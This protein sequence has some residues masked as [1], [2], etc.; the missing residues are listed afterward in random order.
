M[1]YTIDDIIKQVNFMIIAVVVSC[2]INILL[3]AILPHFLNFKKAIKRDIASI[4]PITICALN[5]KASDTPKILSSPHKKIIPKKLIN[6][7]TPQFDVAS[8][9]GK[10]VAFKI[11]QNRPILDRDKIYNLKEVE[12]APILSFRAA[13]L[14]PY[15][16]KRLNIEGYVKVKFLVNKRG[17]VSKIEILKAK[18]E[19]F[20]E[21]AVRKSVSLW[22]F[23]SAEIDGQSVAIWFET[24][25]EF[26]LKED[27]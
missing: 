5:Q 2:L 15:R 27:K 6:L 26:N 23:H 10:D 24:T 13:P 11:T 14:Y 19:G 18:P 3:F 8:L 21:E 16:A 17:D 1:T 9:K 22:K 4:T 25:I 20:F 7:K 12:I